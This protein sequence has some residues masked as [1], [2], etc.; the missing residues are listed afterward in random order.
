MRGKEKWFDIKKRRKSKNL[1]YK[2]VIMVKKYNI[3][4]IKELFVRSVLATVK[5]LLTH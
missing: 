5:K 4:A 2:Q 1:Q 3:E